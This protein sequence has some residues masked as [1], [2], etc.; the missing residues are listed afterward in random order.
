MTV[1]AANR[2]ML[3]GDSQISCGSL[4][5]KGKK[6]YEVNGDFIGM[7]GNLSDQEP[8]IDWYRHKGEKPLL[9]DSFIALVLT[10]KRKLIEYESS[11]VPLPVVEK[12]HAVGGGAHF[13]LGAMSAGAD[14]E[15]AVRL[16][17]K[18]IDGCSLPVVKRDILPR[19]QKEPK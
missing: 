2:E 8:F 11:L 15:Q 9:D 6:V 13:A 5:S 1:I 14:P 18:R 17:C 12:Y 16:T 7:A 19:T 4:A 10:S 3:C